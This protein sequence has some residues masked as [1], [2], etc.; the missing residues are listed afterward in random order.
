MTSE[1]IDDLLWEDYLR[2]CTF[3]IYFENI[4]DYT[5]ENVITCKCK[6]DINL[7]FKYPQTPYFFCTVEGKEFMVR[8]IEMAKLAHLFSKASI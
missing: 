3:E 4:K 6:G 8:K 2:S 5:Y 7:H 1:D